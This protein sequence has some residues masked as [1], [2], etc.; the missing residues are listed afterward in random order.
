MNLQYFNISMLKIFRKNPSNYSDEEL[1]TQYQKNGNVDLL[2]I[3]MERYTVLIYG[4]CLKVLQDETAAEDAYMGIFEKLTLKVQQHDIQSFR[5]WLHVLTRNHCLEILR[6][7]KKHLTVSYD[8]AFM[9][10]EAVE[11]PFMET[12]TNGKLSALSDCLETLKG[13]QKACVQLFYFEGLSYKEIAAQ[14]VIE[15]GKVRSYI[16]NGRRN[17]KICIEEREK[18]NIKE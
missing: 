12:A 6:K 15:I 11:H 8:G 9:Q 10:S 7:Q 17:L 13:E 1:V 16:Q 2:G 5:P 4:V 14:K 3:L 18:V